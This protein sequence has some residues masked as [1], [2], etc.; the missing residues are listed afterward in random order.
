MDTYIP[1]N[2]PN[3]FCNTLK[4]NIC[5]HFVEIQAYIKKN[6]KLIFNMKYELREAPIENIV[7]SFRYVKRICMLIDMQDLQLNITFNYI[8]V[9]NIKFIT[10]HQVTIVNYIPKFNYYNCIL[11]LRIAKMFNCAH[12]AM[13]VALFVFVD[14]AM[15]TV[16]TF[17]R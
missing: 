7:I 1:E 9:A 2:S 3:E 17:Y 4:L 16:I 13:E 14:S 12:S 10:A 15:S 11:N 5:N 8:N 6:F